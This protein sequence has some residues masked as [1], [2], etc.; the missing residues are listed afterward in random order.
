MSDYKR[1]FL[2][3]AA[4]QFCL[5]IFTD[6][7]EIPCFLGFVV[8]YYEKNINKGDIMRPGR[9]RLQNGSGRGVGQPNA[10]GQNRNQAPCKQNPSN[11]NQGRGQGAGRGQG[12]NR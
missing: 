7:L 4:N 9:V 8:I 6:L 11:R 2:N 12:R 10:R 1:L 5:D 3:I